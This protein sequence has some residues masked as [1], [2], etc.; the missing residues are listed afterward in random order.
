MSQGLLPQ[1][2]KDLEPFVSAWALAT[3]KERTEKRYAS[4]MAELQAFYDAMLP[5][6][7]AILDYL[8]QFTL[9][10]MPAEVKRLFYLSLSMAEV[11]SPVELFKQPTVPDTF[12]DPGRLVPMHTQ[13]KGILET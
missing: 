13:L 4:T 8:Q 3:E 6:M 5:R 11:A 2:F 10:K 7:E 9:D 12:A 1:Q